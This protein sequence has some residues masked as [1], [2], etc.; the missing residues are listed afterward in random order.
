[1]M[2][3][4]IFILA[5]VLAV[6]AAG[7]RKRADAGIVPVITEGITYALPRTGLSIRVEA[8]KETFE[9]GP[10]ASFAGQLLG[11]P[12]AKNRPSVK[13]TITHIHFDTFSEPDPEQVY[14]AMGIGAVQV[15]LTA[16]GCLAGVNSGGSASSASAPGIFSQAG[17][18]FKKDGFSISNIQHSAVSGRIEPNMQPERFTTNEKPA[19]A[20]RRIL[21]ARNYR[22]MIVAGLLDEFHPDGEAYHVSLR[23][24]ER[25]EREYMSLFTGRTTYQTYSSGFNFVPASSS[26]KGK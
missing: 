16:S 26:E 5:V 11:I 9:P 15:D 6:P 14:K 2:R 17:E 13:W 24:L 20:A 10:Y 25:T 12:D 8:V 22:Y 19:E 3:K 1:M 23:E 4:L 21:D 7:Q 18:S